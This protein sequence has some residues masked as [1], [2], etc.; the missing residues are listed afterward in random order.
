MEL[1]ENGELYGVPKEAGD[2]EIS[3]RMKNSYFPPDVKTYKFTVL[4]NTDTNV[5]NAEDEGY[6]LTTRIAGI[7]DLT[8]GKYLIVSEGVFDQYTDLYIDG[9][10]MQ[11]GT[12]YDAESGSTR[13]TIAAQSLP[14]SEGTH[15]IG[16]EFRQE[17]SQ[18]KVKAAAQ[19][20]HVSASSSWSGGGGGSSR[21]SGGSSKPADNNTIPGSNTQ[22]GGSSGNN[23]TTP[24]GNTHPADTNTDVSNGKDT[25]LSKDMVYARSYT[26][27]DGDT[28]KSLAK[29][30]YGKSSKWKK[31]YNANKDKLTSSKQLKKGMKLQIPAINYTVKKGDTIKSIAKKYFGANSKWKQ[32][33]Q[34]NQDVVSP[35]LKLK[36][37]QKLVLPVPVVCRI[38]AVKKGDTLEKIAKKFYGRSS[39]WEKIY[40]A[41]KN[42]V[43]AA[44]KVKAGVNLFIPAMTYTVKKGD[45]IKSIAKEYYGKKTEWRQIYNANKDVIPKSKKLKTGTTLVLPVPVDIG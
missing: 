44:K 40:N 38:Y 33:Y 24:S 31:I 37:G 45:A 13:I 39:K 14:K 2:F 4:D 22:S 34:V 8:N 19:N 20:Y 1:M 10:K 27:T 30:F 16:V 29:K 6:K 28:L 26:V 25:T 11:R 43:S 35:S 36:A 21:P 17:K 3:V 7:Y 5:D 41:N 9:E 42:K 18:G 23:G 12:D 15:T 32:I